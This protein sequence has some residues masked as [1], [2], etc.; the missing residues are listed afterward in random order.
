MESTL[1]NM[2]FGLVALPLIASISLFGCGGDSKKVGY[3]D[4]DLP[5]VAQLSVLGAIAKGSSYRVR[6]NSEVVLTGKDSFS[7]YAPILEYKWRQVSGT[8]VTLVERT[9]N[10]VAFTAPP[11]KTNNLL[12]FELTA[13]D[14]NDNSD[15]AQ[16][17]I[18]VYAINDVDHFLA[19]PAT[20]DNSLRLLAA[21]QAGS[22]TGSE[23]EPIALEVE[24]IAHWQNR[25][26]DLDQIS[27]YTEQV[28]ALFPANFSAPT[29]YDPLTEPKNPSFTIQLARLNADDI[30]K[31]FETENR[32]RR[33]DPYN[34][35]T[36]YLEIQVRV[37]SANLGFELF[38]LDNDGQT[39]VA[40][41][42]EPS[43]G[44]SSAQATLK[45]AQAG[46]A[47][48]IISANQLSA[49]SNSTNN[50]ANGSLLQTWLGQSSVNLLTNNVL[51]QLGIENNVT[52]SNYYALIDPEGN[53]AT[54]DNWLIYAGFNDANGKAISDPSIA[55]ALYVNNYDLG[56][57]RDMYLRKAD[58]GNVYSYVT[59]YP[60]VE[61]GL[62]Q[63]QEFAV[64][65]M[66][67]SENP[68]PAGANPKIVKFWSFIQDE[69]SGKFVRVNSM[70]FDGRGE[71]FLPNV[72]TACHQSYPGVGKQ[73]L[74]LADAD[75]GATFI[76]WD[77]DSFLYTKAQDPNL[78]EPSLKV[79]ELNKEKIERFSRENQEAEFKKLNL[80]ALATY[81]GEPERHAAA[82]ALIHGWYG[83]EALELPVDQLPENST[84]NGAYTQPGW[85]AEPELYHKVFA[86]N[87]RIC[88]T[89][90]AN[91]KTNFD[92]Y[93]ELFNNE[94]LVEYTYV[95]GL[96]PLARL[97][98]DRFWVSYQ[99]DAQA[100]ADLLRE[101]IIARGDTNLTL[102]T[103]PGT[104][105]AQFT[106][107]P[108]NP[109][110][111]QSVV[112][113]A[114]AS[115]FAKDFLWQITN[116]PDNS[117]TSLVNSTGLTS[118]F[119]P[120]TPAGDYEVTLTVTNA[121]GE[122][123]SS[124]QTISTQDRT[125]LA[126]CIAANTSSLTNEG[127]LQIPV[128]AR[129]TE[130]GD[131]QVRI[132][133]LGQGSLGSATLNSDG[134][135]FH[136][137]LNDPFVRG[138]DQVTFAL[139]DLNG[140]ASQ[141]GAGCSGLSVVQ[142]D[143]STAGTFAPST[144]AA[145]VHPSLDTSAIQVNWQAPSAIAPDSYKVFRDGVEIADLTST[146][147]TDTGLTS[148][149][150]YSYT[151]R[152]VVNGFVS[153]PSSQASATTLALSPR[154]PVATAT[155]STGVSVSWDL[156]LGNNANLADPTQYSLARSQA[157]YPATPA[158]PSS[159][160]QS[161]L[162]S[163]S[164]NDSGL[165]PGTSYR[166]AVA[167][168]TSLESSNLVATSSVTTPPLP[169]SN[170]AVNPGD[171][172]RTQVVVDWTAPTGH[173]SHYVLAR[174]EGSGN[175]AEIATPATTQYVDLG[176]NESS[177][178]T[179]QV[180]SAAGSVYSNTQSSSDITTAS[181]GDGQPSDFAANVN[182]ASYTNASQIVLTWTPP[183]AFTPDS[184]I[185]RRDNN[186]GNFVVVAS[187][188]LGSANS[189][190]DTGLN[191][192]STHNY[193]LIAEIGGVES[194]LVTDIASTLA[195][196]PNFNSAI[197]NSSTQITLSWGAPAAEVES[198]T[199][200]RTGLTVN[201]AV[202]GYVDT[203]LT[204]GKSYL[205]TV[206]AL[207]GSSS[208]ASTR[209]AA[210]AP[211]AP[212]ALGISAISTT[213][214]QLNW[215]AATGNDNDG[216]IVYDIYR[217]D[218]G[219]SSAIASNVVS[220]SFL[221]TGLTPATNY[222]YRVF[223]KANAELSKT[224]TSASLSTLAA[225]PTL[226]SAAAVSGNTSTIVLS[227][228]ARSSSAITGFNV[229]RSDDGYTTPV[230]SNVA[231]TSTGATNTGLSVATSYSYRITAL[232]SGG[233]SAVSNTASGATYPAVPT[234][235]SATVDSTSQITVN[236][237]AAGN[238]ANVRYTVIPSSGSLVSNINGVSRAMTGLT[239]HTN[240]TFTVTANAN[241]LSSNAS[242]PSANVRT[243]TSYADVQ[244]QVVDVVGCTSCHLSTDANTKTRIINFQACITNDTDLSD[245][246]ASMVGVSITG[247]QR[248]LIVDWFTDGQ[249]N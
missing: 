239:S 13:I 167:A 204:P 143:T 218:D 64:V 117:I 34:I 5:P 106:A 12:T 168:Q 208:A 164:T 101:H 62:E 82:T 121:D 249:Q 150:S 31:N 207:Q 217:S 142:I 104:P 55:H 147:F 189:Y 15:T 14:G 68:D 166:Y 234:G 232:T 220:T 247:A 43:S 183:V 70:N 20:P 225:A 139:Q 127:T 120:D 7:D 90:M 51:N 39:L 21:L 172:A 130:L 56:F 66:E 212:S 85:A 124:S 161:N 102:D 61:T 202:P 231:G 226:T 11:V 87:C 203:G 248:Q 69:R 246:S 18:E 75:L 171:D 97:S 37:V 72:C 219:Y 233:E 35:S 200:S 28:N 79:T 92:S 195:L 141:P 148:A 96:M 48:T 140:T 81:L 100:P 10:A 155:S 149:S 222:G 60:S 53:F 199:L 25:D 154:N 86:R 95:Q 240:Y 45:A 228:P 238:G 214:L 33:L 185:L 153:N 194:P 206:T 145:S 16:I 136:Y 193:Q 52:A 159:M 19:D 99:N 224:Y 245:C 122:Q 77:L 83:D 57:G 190:T 201:N 119:N 67:Y 112:L 88:H 84:F 22:T 158:L 115:K 138:V 98:M 134:Q 44:V 8:P 229:Y 223:A 78:V 129:M 123:T 131:G 30:N 49:P 58:N 191:P 198:Y 1:H 42:L 47:K 40:S 9:S 177:T 126:D 89:Q 137:A 107:T 221:N 74:D 113:D 36:A 152:S 211:T 230:L 128:V 174:R 178:Y 144:L 133:T 24:T 29:N 186:D 181:A 32:N 215:T 94:K 213:S 179:Y 162:T 165:T 76:P 26:G 38:A 192:A 103:F 125:P 163:T 65:A 105:L 6:S 160:V 169:V 187:C 243:L 146:S 227:W 236:W 110:I 151:A 80:G 46:L 118:S 91:E 73:F 4:D 188:C 209:S 109:N 71:Q 242:S 41:D 241:G 135:G 182:A 176:L 3:Q 184:Y 216:A 23:S 173:V 17:D 132:T 157:N 54:L 196:A 2:R 237:S 59:N 244:T 210:T 63:R 116:K 108:A 205:Y 114:S 156:P 197:T 170:L 180:T 235:V 50:N 111:D 93:D 27:V 175:Y